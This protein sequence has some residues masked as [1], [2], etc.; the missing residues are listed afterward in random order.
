M[1]NEMEAGK[2]TK[3]FKISLGIHLSLSFLLFI[4]GYFEFI[5][6]SWGRNFFAVGTFVL[7]ILAFIVILYVI[8]DKKEVSSMDDIKGDDEIHDSDSDEGVVTNLGD[9]I[10][11]RGEEDDEEFSV[12]ETLEE[13]N[14]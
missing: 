3:L 14:N 13:D 11:K 10:S 7:I 9:E 12:E 2:P 6:Y 8:K 5:P 4:L 1:E